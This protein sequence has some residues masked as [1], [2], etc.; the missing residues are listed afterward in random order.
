MNFADPRTKGALVGPYTLLA[1]IASGGMA[2]VY[3]GLRSG[4]GGFERYVAIKQLHPHLA[5]EREFVEMFLDEARL[6]AKIHHPNV[7]NLSEIGQAEDGHY[8]VMEYVEGETLARLLSRATER[9]EA[10]PL[11]VAVR[12]VLDALAGLHAAHELTSET[13]E[14]LGIVHR[15]VSPQNIL[16]GTNGVSKISDFGVAWAAHRLAATRSGQLKGKLSYMAPE[17]ATKKAVEI[18]RRADV[19]AMGIVLWEALTGEGLFRAESE[20]QTFHKLL[21]DPIAHPT[22]KA[23]AVPLAL[24]DVCMRALARDP[25]QRYGSAADFAEALEAVAKEVGAVGRPADVSAYVTR[26]AGADLSQRRARVRAVVD[27][28]ASSPNRPTELASRSSTAPSKLPS[29]VPNTNAKDPA[30]STAAVTRNEDVTLVEGQS[31]KKHVRAWV[32]A[33]TLTLV[34]LAGAVGVRATMHSGTA[35][36][37]AAA[38]E[39]PPLTEDPRAPLGLQGRTGAS[40]FGDGTNPAAAALPPSSTERAD[41]ATPGGALGPSTHPANTGMD[42]VPARPT[43]ATERDG[44]TPRGTAVVAGAKGAGAHPASAA[45]STTGSPG[46]N[47]ESASVA[48]TGATARDLSTKDATRVSAPA[49]EASARTAEDEPVRH[50][51]PYLH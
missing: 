5:T 11:P 45:P 3:L 29:L 2:T 8:I 33:G 1:K 46:A 35:S 22:D 14:P 26:S 12:I 25:D 10:L 44:R 16:V 38:A 20:A 50:R 47:G 13:G 4:E 49:A 17:Q 37:R 6:S 15:D 28:L 42:P 48:A 19:F 27:E 18:D 39:P 31:P 51:N 7:V 21:I 36:V 34:M 43:R 30:N 9:R 24:G 32:I 40:P 23:P 41:N